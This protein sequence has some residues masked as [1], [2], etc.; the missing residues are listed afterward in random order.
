MERRA[1]PHCFSNDSNILARLSM[2]LPYPL[3]LESAQR[4]VGAIVFGTDLQRQKWQVIQS[5]RSE[6]V[7]LV[8]R[9]PTFED[10]S[11]NT[12]TLTETS[13]LIDD[14]ALFMHSLCASLQPHEP[15]VVF[16]TPPQAVPR[17]SWLSMLNSLDYVSI[18]LHFECYMAQLLAF[19]YHFNQATIRRLDNVKSTITLITYGEP[20]RNP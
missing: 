11:E 19:V 17:F 13:K 3:P 10:D 14:Y 6:L 8:L 15:P 1:L 9:S 20:I 4:N 7:L 2:L 5:L 18:S 12:T 16:L